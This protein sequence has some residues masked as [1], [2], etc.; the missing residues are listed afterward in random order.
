MYCDDIYMIGIEYLE[1]ERISVFLFQIAILTKKQT[2]VMRSTALTIWE[3]ASIKRT[4]S[5]TI[6]TL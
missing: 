4:L 6:S 1:I 5:C 3:S 2:A